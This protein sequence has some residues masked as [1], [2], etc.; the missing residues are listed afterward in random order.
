MRHRPKRDPDAVGEDALPDTAL[1]EVEQELPR[2]SGIL[3]APTQQVACV[4][5][6]IVEV[7]LVH[8]VSIPLLLTG[9]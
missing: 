7:G 8:H 3:R 9:Y 2:S 4:R 5:E 1:R 6:T